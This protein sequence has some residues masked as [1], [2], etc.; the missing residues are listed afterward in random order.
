MLNCGNCQVW[1][2]AMGSESFSITPGTHSRRS[3][4]VQISLPALISPKLGNKNN[5]SLL[6]L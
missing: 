2:K 6:K 5:E 3:S 1:S 4:G